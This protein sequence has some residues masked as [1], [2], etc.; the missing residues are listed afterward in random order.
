M[1]QARSDWDQEKGSVAALSR[2]MLFS[3]AFAY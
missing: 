2:A 1:V 3:T